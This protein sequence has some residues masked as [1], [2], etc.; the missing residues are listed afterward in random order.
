MDDREVV[1]AIVAGDP[2]GLAS[3]YDRYAASLYGYCRS[4]LREPADA[5]D[6]VQ[7][8]FVIATAKVGALRDPYRLR[9]WL[10]AVA[11]NECHRK[12]RSKE[13]A[14]EIGDTADPMYAADAA[15]EPGLSAQQ[16][17]LRELVRDAIS[18]LNPPDREVIELNLRHELDGTELVAA[19]GVSR[20]HAHA[21]ASRARAQLEKALGALLV[22]RTGR[23]GCQD[24]D[25]L[26]ADWDGRLTVLL[27]KRVNRHIEQCEACD[28]RKHRALRPAM[29]YGFAPL[30]ILPVWLRHQTLQLC[31]DGAPEAQ[32]FKRHVVQ[33]AG[34]FDA[35]G[36][37]R[38]LRNIGGFGGRRGGRFEPGA[39][40]IAAASFA[41]AAIVIIA[42]VAL[43]GSP[44]LHTAD[45]K[46]S[47]G[48]GN[49]AVAASNTG[50]PT[51]LV[52]M[53]TAV[54]PSITATSA[55]PTAVPSQPPVQ[56]SKTPSSS[57][58]AKP[59]T[60]PTP[61]P[62]P[63]ASAS[64]TPS[65]SLTLHTGSPVAPPTTTPP[66]TAPP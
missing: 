48:A 11:R 24:L 15:A 26:L 30:P 65:P 53:P 42:M 60:S 17:E 33:D 62:S 39:A 58:S 40:V 54:P 13:A 8:T 12:L 37:P 49:V 52:P 22:A 27:R 32:E 7:D 14:A 66:T 3:A 44:P 18:G 6:V 55:L 59:S 51:P 21:M 5:A 64:P 50:S 45:R 36:F 25:D 38:A 35:E 4:L 47:T 34:A 16:A 23:R 9:P 41:A 61:A 20:S 56:P 57:K 1:A 10:Y 19:L 28:D 43:R 63:S 31:A 29:L 46:T 2:R